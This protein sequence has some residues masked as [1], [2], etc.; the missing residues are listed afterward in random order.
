MVPDRQA[1]LQGLSS[2]PHLTS[3]VAV[4]LYKPI[5]YCLEGSSALFCELPF[6]TTPAADESD[7]QLR[8]KKRVARELIRADESIVDRRCIDGC[9]R[10]KE[11]TDN[12]PYGPV[13][14]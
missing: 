8:R 4:A 14:A 12:G 7:T 6:V 9:L 5:R 1:T 13:N 11:A 3:S 2:I 10:S